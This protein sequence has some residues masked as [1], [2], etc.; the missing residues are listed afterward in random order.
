MHSSNQRG[1]ETSNSKDFLI[2]ME[3]NG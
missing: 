3:P 2:K 1:W